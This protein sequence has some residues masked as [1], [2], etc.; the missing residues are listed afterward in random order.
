[1]NERV[2]TR[3]GPPSRGPA[4]GVDVEMRGCEVGEDVEALKGEAA[5]VTPASGGRGCFDARDRVPRGVPSAG[6]G[7]GDG[8]GVS[9]AQ[10]RI[11]ESSGVTVP[12]DAPCAVGAVADES[13]VVGTDQDVAPATEV[14]GFGEGRGLRDGTS[15]AC[16]PC[17]DERG[18]GGL[19]SGVEVGDH[20]WG[21]PRGRDADEACGPVRGC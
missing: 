16:S 13:R 5:V 21:K 15:G 19:P 2:G 6:S 7:V 9:R 1:M 17:R 11:V 3:R 4:C 12:T 14:D 10:Q 18:G 8:S 20:A